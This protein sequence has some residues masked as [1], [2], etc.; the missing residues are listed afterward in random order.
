REDFARAE[1]VDANTAADLDQALEQLHGLHEAL[2]AKLERDAPN[3]SKLEE[4]V[5]ECQEFLRHFV[6]EVVP[7][8]A[9]PGEGD[10]AGTNSVPG[11]ALPGKGPMTR[12][13]AYRQIAQIANVLEHLE[14][15]SPIPDLLRRAVE[16]GRMPFRKLIRE[17]VREQTLLN[18]VN[19]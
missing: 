18:E 4:A 5:R 13:E 10:V 11:I 9:A 14:P 6:K 8:A 19:R 12:E 7:A 17:I 15:H 16:L 2:N 1:P 3:L